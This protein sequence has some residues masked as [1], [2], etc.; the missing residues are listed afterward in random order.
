[1]AC[2][3]I[4]FSSS[5]PEKIRYIGRSKYDSYEPRLSRHLLN[6]KNGDK[7]HVCN[8]IRKSIDSNNLILAMIL[9]ANLS[10][11]ES[12]HKEIYYIKKYKKEGHDLTNM[13]NGGE[14]RGLGYKLPKETREKIGKYN[15]ILMKAQHKKYKENGLVWGKDL[16]PKQRI[17]DE[18]RQRIKQE[19]ERGLS[20]REIARIL[21][22]EGI[23]TAYGGRWTASTINYVLNDNTEELK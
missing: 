7:S 12:I 17:S 6:A 10:W 19:K 3:Y 13:S 21:D 18:I 5:E 1:M 4:L 23:K 8:W 15:K 14:G 20:L 22:A 16:G 11:E 2:I 9:E